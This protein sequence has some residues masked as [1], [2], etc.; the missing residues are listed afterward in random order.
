MFDLKVGVSF[1]WSSISAVSA[2]SAVNVPGWMTRRYGDSN[3]AVGSAARAHGFPGYV[4]CGL[5]V[6]GRSLTEA[7]AFGTIPQFSPMGG[8]SGEDLEART[9]RMACARK[10]QVLSKFE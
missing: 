5:R 10:C 3:I 2:V 8:D 7:S 6:G 9:A 1:Y 4:R